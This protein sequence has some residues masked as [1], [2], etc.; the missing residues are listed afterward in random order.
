S[1]F[2]EG[3]GGETPAMKEGI[4]DHVWTWQEFLTYHIQL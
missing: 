3:K 4:T 1:N 2:V